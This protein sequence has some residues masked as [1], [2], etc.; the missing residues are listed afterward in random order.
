MCVTYDLFKNHKAEGRSKLEERIARCRGKTSPWKPVPDFVV[1]QSGRGIVQGAS[2]AKV[3]RSGSTT[4]WTGNREWGEKE[5][6]RHAFRDHHQV[7]HHFEY[8]IHVLG[9]FAAQ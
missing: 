4:M 7:E 6:H 3:F 1:I 2:R 8:P 5:L 9:S